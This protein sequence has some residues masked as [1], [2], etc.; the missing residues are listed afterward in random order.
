MKKK[1]GGGVITYIRKFKNFLIIL[2]HSSLL[3]SI[4]ANIIPPSKMLWI[5]PFGFIFI[6]LV[7]LHIALFLVYFRRR[8]WIAL[9]SLVLLFF[10][11]KYIPRTLTYHIHKEEKGLKI[12]SWN[13]KNFD[14]YNWSKNKQT[15]KSMLGLIE[16]T[17]GDILCFQ[18]FFTNKENFDNI[19]EITKLGYPYHYF[20]SAFQNGKSNQW[21]LAIFSRYP[22]GK[23]QVIPLHQGKNKMNTAIM[24]RI[25]AK[26]RT[27]TVFNAHF[28]SIHFDYDD[29]N[30]IGQ[31]QSDWDSWTFRQMAPILR[32]YFFALPRREA[33]IET[34]LPYLE[35]V[36]S[37][38]ILC[39]DLNDIPNSYTYSQFAN[40][41]QDAFIEK[42]RGISNTT[43]VL[44]GLL[45]IDYIFTSSDI[46]VKEYKRIRNKLSDHH[47]VYTVI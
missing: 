45:R 20:Y 5:A 10:S 21:G 15:R 16:Q 47:L 34:L 17:R 27:Y 28:Q 23:T 38:L 26:G 11:A 12:V 33:Q 1:S 29:Y 2:L 8:R 18:E 22:I 44:R 25:K 4:C 41:L 7:I 30:L 43:G 36:P 9:T 32:K 31:I 39:T 37:N 35:L 42:G 13:V 40:I 3:C 24:A 6:P 19:S 46:V 14:L